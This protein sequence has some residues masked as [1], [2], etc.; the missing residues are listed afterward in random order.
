MKVTRTSMIS[1]KQN[2]LDLDITAT[3]IIAYNSGALLQ[4]AFPNLTAA[5]REFYKTGITAEEW[6]V[7][8][9]PEEEEDEDDEGDEDDWSYEDGVLQK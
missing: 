9:P 7:A 3:Q 2:S 6:A 8:F 1:G 5:E 4:D